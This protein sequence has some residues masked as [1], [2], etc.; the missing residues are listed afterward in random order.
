LEVPARKI[1]DEQWKE[2]WRLRKIKQESAAETPASNHLK[3]G[4]LLHQT[5]YNETVLS[6]ILKSGIVSGEIGDGEKETRPE[7]NET[8]YCADFFVNQGDRSFADY[9]TFATSPQFVGKLKMKPMES[10]NC[11]TEKNDG[12]A[13]VIDPTQPELVELLG[14]SATGLDVRLL[15][16]FHVRFPKGT[17]KP[18]SAKRHLT[19]LV[20]I[21]A[22]FITTIVVGGMIAQDQQQLNKLKMMVANAELDIP[23]RN[24]KGERL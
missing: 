14:R 4:Y 18:E 15:E 2:F 1:L 12:I 16:D 21:P 13:I 24:T 9:V 19:V 5:G 6:H 11:P 7:D 8:H 10:Y 3:D 23:I 20:G 22:N 17:D